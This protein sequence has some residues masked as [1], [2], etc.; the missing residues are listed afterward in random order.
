MND[1]ALLYP[2][3]PKPLPALPASHVQEKLDLILKK[4]AEKCESGG[5]SKGKAMPPRP[6]RRQPYEPRRR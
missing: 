6:V 2:P 1:N 3:H 5:C 4:I